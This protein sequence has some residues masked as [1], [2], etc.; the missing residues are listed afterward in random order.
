MNPKKQTRRTFKGSADKLRF[1]VIVSRFNY[2]ITAKLL[3]GVEHCLRDHGVLEK[4]WKVVFCPGAFELPQVANQL[5]VQNK[6]DA[7]I[8]LGAIIRGETPHFE[9]I[10]AET[11]RGIQDVA[12][13]NSLPVVFGV[14]TTDNEQQAL[15]RVGGAQGHKGWDAALTALEMATLFTTLNHSPR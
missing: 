12:L 3:E 10:S 5:A 14:L 8:C 7:I 15:D 13:R 9:Y 2:H 6:W 11:A 1:A 4:N